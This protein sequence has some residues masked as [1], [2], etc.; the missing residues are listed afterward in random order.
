MR[1]TLLPR[2]TL[3]PPGVSPAPET[4][5][6]DSFLV[7]PLFG[8]LPKSQGSGEEALCLF[9]LH[10]VP[11]ELASLLGFSNQEVILVASYPYCLPSKSA[12]YRAFSLVQAAPDEFAMRLPHWSP[13]VQVRVQE[14][15]EHSKMTHPYLYAHSRYGNVPW[16]PT[17]VELFSTD[18]AI[19]HVED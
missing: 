13:E 12:F 15:D 18:W 14:P 11:I 2:R 7:G 19:V 1:A 6:G 4:K 10:Q 16:I 8:K 9:P 3:Q 17:Q 5:V